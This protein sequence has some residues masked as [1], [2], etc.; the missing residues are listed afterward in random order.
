MG[1]PRLLIAGTHSGVGKTTISTGIMTALALRGMTVQGF[2][3]GPDYIDPSYHSGATG[4]ISRNLDTWLLGENLVPLFEK[5]S[6]GADIAIIEGVMGMFDGIKGQKAAG[7]CANVAA[8]VG[9]PVILIVDVR[10]TAYSAAALVHGF[11]SFD[12][13]VRVAGVI[14]NRVG[15]AN[16][17][18]MVREAVEGLGIP[19]VGHLGREDRFTLPERHLGL[20]P[21]AERGSQADYFK[22]LAVVIE[23]G[24]DLDRIVALARDWQEERERTLRSGETAAWAVMTGPRRR[25][26]GLD[27][28]GTGIETSGDAQMRSGGDAQ[29][30]AAP[31]AADPV[32]I[33]VAR[34][35]AFSFYYQDGLDSLVSLGAEIVSFSP[36][37]DRELPPG[38]EGII[39]GGGFPESFPQQLE[40]NQAMH[41]SLRQAHARG[42]PVY[43]ECG[44]LMYLCREI[45]GFE[46]ESFAGAGLVPAVC[47]MYP[48]LQGMGYREG[49]FVQDSLLGP[50]GARARGHEFH[51]SSLQYERES[52]AYRLTDAGGE[53]KGPEGYAGKNILAS[54]LHLN[55]AGNPD[56]AA[57]FLQACRQSRE[58]RLW[59]SR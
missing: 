9:A 2:K 25:A 28:A 16:H 41:R 10:S 47:A 49:V 24:I 21:L 52:F 19:V 57:S 38:T 3:V 31:R 29:E 51:Y 37:H 43:A 50:K 17:L 55:F 1:T 12:P 59:A 18:G 23:Q 39:I 7:S 27:Q 20:V 11:A 58:G 22:A 26:L 15:S 4:R 34:D 48:R 46:G 13:G 56:L 35:E 54:Y 8:L 32:R 5:A 42:V 6:A 53:D 33:A 30:Q 40:D 45:K 36:L 44:G 14:L